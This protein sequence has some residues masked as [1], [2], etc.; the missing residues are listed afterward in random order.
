MKSDAD[1]YKVILAYDPT[2][3]EVG[4]WI[5]AISWSLLLAVVAFTAIAALRKRSVLA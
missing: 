1:S 4:I 3:L 2:E 5:S